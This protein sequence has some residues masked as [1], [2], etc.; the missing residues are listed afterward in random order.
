MC[1]LIIIVEFMERREKRTL[2]G[3]IN[4]V[5]LP[6]V[7]SVWSCLGLLWDHRLDVWTEQLH[8][9]LSRFTEM[10]AKMV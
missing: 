9:F 4:H 10:A 6:P 5:F 2:F 8:Q 1:Y 7:D 3:L